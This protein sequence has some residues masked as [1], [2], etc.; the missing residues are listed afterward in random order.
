MKCKAQT[1]YV[2]LLELILKGAIYLRQFNK[3]ISMVLVFILVFASVSGIQTPVVY[4]AASDLFIS[5]YIEGS[6]NNK[7]IEIY[8]GTGNNIDLS[9]FNYTVELYPNGAATAG[10]TV[11]LSGILA[12]GDV[13][14]IANSSA[15]E[16]IKTKSDI[17]NSVAN[18]NGDDAIVLKKN[19]TIIDVFGKVGEDPGTSWGDGA[20][21]DH[22]M[23]RKS[24]ITQGDT[25]PGDA[26][27]PT[28]EWDI[29]AKDTF[30]YLGSHTMDSSGG[31]SEPVKVANVTAIPGADQVFPGTEVKLFSAT[32]GASVY[33]AVYYAVYAPDY[34]GVHY[35]VFDENEPI[36]VNEP[37][38]IKAY[39]SK[40]GLENSD[41][42]EFEYSLAQEMTIADA[43]ELALGTK[44]IFEGKV[45]SVPG[46]FG[47]KSF[48]IQD[49][50]AGA[51]VYTSSLISIPEIGN[52]VRIEGETAEYSGKFEIV[53]E[54]IEITDNGTA[55]PAAKAVSLSQI[56]EENEGVLVKL[57]AVEITEI[58]SDSY[59]S[60]YIT[61]ND[62]I[63][64]VTVKLD[65]RTG[66]TSD[67][68]TVQA[69]DYVD[70]TGVVEQS[71]NN[72]AQYRVM[73]RSLDDIDTTNV[74]S[75]SA[76][77]ALPDDSPAV[78]QGIVISKPGSF[79][80]KSFYIQDF[81]SGALVYTSS[82]DSAVVRGSRL[83][84]TGKTDSYAGK[85]EIVPS[86]IEILSQ[87]AAE[88]SPKEVSIEGIAETNEAV[89]VTLKDV[90][91]QSITSDTYNNA[92]ITVESGTNAGTVR[93]DSRT[94][95]AY[96]NLEIAAGDLVNV[97]G[98]VEQSKETPAEYRVMLRDLNDIA[99]SENDD[100]VAPVISHTAVTNGN[101]HQD[102]EINAEITDNR[103]IASVKLYYR[104]KGSS[105]YSVIDMSASNN[106]Y[107]AVIPK[108][109]LSVSG[110]EYY[111]EASDGINIATSPDNI[112][113]PYEVAISN[114]DIIGPEVT[115]VTPAKDAVLPDTETRTVISAAFSDPS[116]IDISSVKLLVDGTDVTAGAVIQAGGVSYQ[117]S[118][119]L[120]LGK[121]SVSVEVSD[122]LGNKTEYA[123]SFT[124]GEI[125]YKH[126][127][128]Q[129]H[130]HT[131]EISDGQGTLD[132]AYTW[133]RDNGKADFFAVTD[134]SNWFDND[135]ANENITELSQSTSS[136]WKL[137]HSKADQYN[138][139][140]EF[141][142]IAGYEMTWSGSTGGWGHMNTFNT[143]WFASRTNSSMDLPSYYAKI[144]ADTDS[145]SQ[146]NHP[147]KT[148]GD[149]ADFG[150]YSKSVDNVVHLVEVGNGEGPVHGSGYFPSYEYYT[151]A[152]DKGWHVAPSNN[153]DNHK[154][155]WI[156]AND[157]RTVILSS[158]L[159]RDGIYDAIR[160]L[161]VYSTEDKNME[162]TYKVNDNIMGSILEAPEKLNIYI[163]VKDPDEEDVIEEVSI[164]ANGGVEVASKTFDDNEALWELELN[165]QYSYYYVR[166]DQKD[167]DI[168]VTAP[169]WTDE[170]TLV[171]ISKVEVSQDP[172]IVDNPVNI[173]ATVYNNGESPLG[174]VKLEFYKNSMEA[175]NK[176]GE[177]TIASIA[178]G[179]LGEAAVEWTTDKTGKYNLYV[180]TT[181]NIGG[182]EKVFS[183]ST[184]V[185][186]ANSEDVIKI[187]LD[188]AHYNA[189]ISGDYA[190]KD[191]T[192][193]DI[194]KEKKYMLVENNDELT[195]SDL[196]NAKLLIITDPQGTD[197][198]DTLK[199]SVFT[200]AEVAAIKEYTDNGGSLIVCSKADYKDGTGEYSNGAQLNKILEA[201]GTK[202][203][204]NDDEVVDEV[205]NG[206]QSYRLYFDKY[207]STKYNLT[208]DIPEGTVYSFYSGCSVVQSVYGQD[209]A[210]DWL[211][212][213]HT[214]TGIIDSDFQNDNVPVAQ[215]DV[216]AIG[217]EQ[218][219]GGA[220]IIVAGTV[221]FSDF[222]TASN[223][224]AYSNKQITEN[225]LNWMI[226]PKEVEL[227][228]IAEVRADNDKDG[229][230]DLMGERFAVEGRVTAQ[231]EAVTPKNAFFEVIYVQDET[232]GI[233]VFGVSAT[234]LPLGTKV[235]ITGVVDQ[236]DGDSE[237]SVENEI[238]DVAVL[239]DEIILVEPM[240]MSTGNSML[241]QNEGWLIKVQG[242]VT[243]MTENSLYLNDGS[244]EA[245]VYVNGYINDGTDNAEMR[246]K[247]N[248]AIRIGDTVSA[249]G[250]SSQDPEGHRL[251]VRNTAEIIRIIAGETAD[252]EDDDDRTTTAT[253]SSTQP[254]TA[255]LPESGQS[256]SPTGT[257]GISAE[258][259]SITQTGSTAAVSVQ[260]DA[261]EAAAQLA[262]QQS[263][264]SNSAAIVSISPQLPENVSEMN[265]ELPGT[266]VAGLGQNGVGLQIN[267]QIASIQLSPEA[268][269]SLP[270]SG[271]VSLSIRS[272]D[273]GRE[274][275]KLPDGMIPAGSGVNLELG[276]SSNNASGSIIIEISIGGNVNRDL[277]GLYYYNESTGE[278]TFIG[279]RIEGSM[280]QG[281]TTHNSKYFALEYQKQF[282]DTKA[283]LW[284]SKYVDSMAAKHIMGGYPD[285]TFRGAAHITRGEFAVALVKVLGLKT[286][287]YKGGFGDVKSSDYYAGAI[288]TLSDMEIMK[289][290]GKIF[291]PT[292]SITREE[293]FAVIGRVTGANVIDRDNIQNYRDAG[294]L[295]V[296]AVDGA[297]KAIA[298]KIIIGDGNRLNPKSMLSRYEAAAI[299]YRLFNKQ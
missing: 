110:I 118:Q 105:E 73:I 54:K 148:F 9:L 93:L 161:R 215:G 151:R 248:P 179:A 280:L 223:D 190:G 48:Y 170:V 162:I 115:N 235:R 120:V 63:N 29:Y 295:S 188:R 293:I 67:N 160:N 184:T 37:L 55:E 168:A 181:I 199:K 281:E 94:G 178:A 163:N 291:N 266:L 274:I 174:D 194:F 208:D 242:T 269:R 267:T 247:W 299:F 88:F 18:F 282:E 43:K 136:K 152:L 263:A 229:I 202:L 85:F 240:L 166:I 286:T 3:Y 124:I 41:I 62:G 131:G 40:N 33:Y 234:P 270:V 109:E 230:P 36:V 4:A 262:K 91:V 183:G 225:I 276:L 59:K 238:N 275:D 81:V 50:T 258:A 290:D 189:Y 84:I 30:T 49:E 122:K 79:G 7:A 58:T 83:L 60:A 134:H 86:G 102:L 285:N 111:I 195:A 20:T 191:L 74:I 192:L 139:D 96:S 185:T 56:S 213:G 72:P 180:R 116:D 157:A 100:K 132:E 233:T 254:G 11:T 121:H 216:N 172:Q 22:T 283:N 12:D 127:Y 256:T 142:A 82:V 144:A 217:A 249:V 294:E 226:P 130:S 245:R 15:S 47:T 253:T 126:Y 87:E 212:K 277:V 2:L 209:E 260:A 16:A 98:I 203:R 125:K 251:R 271:N 45:T 220:K 250:L 99:I 104:V 200:D 278:L 207:V 64:G 259:I 138:K 68:V 114:A 193:R 61:I 255:P 95:F 265:L 205:N 135:T 261:I 26:F 156:T 101:I 264:A 80:Q 224:N 228:K 112:A 75:M 241:E 252:D 89:L 24:S 214:T 119:D 158:E 35:E 140:G 171:G 239:S 92:T 17:T 244:G 288:Q 237:L 27:V 298:E 51:L 257:V 14:V 272:A 182:V 147:G 76:A 39:A 176:I 44:G 219:S 231:S 218:L 222:E 57:R 107:S 289:G 19:G 284:Y 38:M 175:E 65:N 196:E 143:P 292:T 149:F 103:Q 150:Y 106:V 167:K 198:S 21:V 97:V 187:V 25:N 201:V 137:M 165:P 206:G 78:I 197:K 297:G 28:A 8:N 296:W 164:I 6:S 287:A 279:G 146:L 268:L 273:P 77:R 177:D 70:V 108:A 32:E 243:R 128:G 155:G 145:I 66:E 186:F 129:L 246:G 204:V 52:T 123:W 153:Q 236:Y 53:P 169:V 232:G 210:I 34:S 173:S 117:P 13:F 221:F 141:V 69:G 154:A 46:S 10:N 159:T 71:S 5:E 1:L 90:R 31:G 211:V 23:V 113:S 227:K 42:S 133:A